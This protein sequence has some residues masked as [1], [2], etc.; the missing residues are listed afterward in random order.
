MGYEKER[1]RL[2]ITGF[3]AKDDMNSI[4]TVPDAKGITPK[5]NVIL[6]FEGG[7]KVLENLEIR[8]E[9]AASGLIKD[10]RAD[11][12]NGTN[13]NIVGLLLKNRASSEYFNAIR[14]GIDYS[15]KKSTLGVGYE[16]VDPDYE[17]LGAYFFN[18]DLESITLNSSTTLFDNKVSFDFNIGYQRDDLKNQKQQASNRTVGALNVGYKP[19]E[20]LMITASYSNFRT[21]TNARVNQFEGI[22]DDNLLDEADELLDYKQLSQN[23]NININYVLSQERKATTKFK[24]KLCF[25]RCLQC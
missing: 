23:A 6:S 7:Y 2:G 21:F 1:Y 25:G 8:A 22:N 9:Y 16:R 12:L 3:Y 11:I 20:V 17:T 15:F 10:T 4:A 13:G 24:C 19:S 18:N 14:A 5:E